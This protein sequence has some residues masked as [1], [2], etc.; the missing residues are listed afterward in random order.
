MREMLAPT[1][2][3]IGAGLGDSVGLITDG[4]FSGGTYGLVVGHVAPGGRGRRHDR[5]GARKATRSRSTRSGAAAARRRRGRA[6]APARGVAAAAAALHARR[7]GEVRASG[8]EQQPRRRHGPGLTSGPWR[9]P[10]YAAGGVRGAGSPRSAA[11]AQHLDDADVPDAAAEQLE[12]RHGPDTL[13]A[14]GPLM[15][16]DRPHGRSVSYRPFGCCKRLELVSQ[17]RKARSA[18]CWSW[19]CVSFAP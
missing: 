13:P 1:S 18:R 10:D 3:I 17:A 2:A 11:L 5:A 15:P 8:L 19:S 4:R 6:G 9:P 14:D 7:P 16:L 12:L